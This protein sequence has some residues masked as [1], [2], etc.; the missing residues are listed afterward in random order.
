MRTEAVAPEISVVVPV[1][2]EEKNIRPFLARLIPTLEKIGPYEVIFSLDPCPDR[3][4]QVISEEIAKNP[5]I[6][7]LVFSRRFGQPAATMAGIYHSQGETVVAIDVDLQDPPELIAALYAKYKEGNDVVYAKRSSRKGET[8]IKKFV[9]YVGYKLINSISNFEIP[10]NTGDFRLMSRRVVENLK[11][12]KETN[13]FLR[14]LVGYVGFKQS[15]VVYERDERASG[16][17]NYNRY[18]GSLWIGINGIVGFSNELLTW[19]LF[20]GIGIA[21]LSFAAIIALAITFLLGRPYP[22]GIPTT[23]SLVL[24][25]GGVQLVCVGILG[26]YIGR[27]YDEVKQRPRFIVDRFVAHSEIVQQAQRQAIQQESTLNGHAN[28]FVLSG[29]SPRSALD[30]PVPTEAVQ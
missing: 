29:T 27:I 5:S 23:I 18:L 2:K 12:L 6:K 3:T 24:F 30:L 14:G 28:S 20:A 1:Y 4:E 8:V 13:C 19:V 22:M 17:G 25:M 11:L 10:R 26:Q 16:I 21:T 9:S 15:F 7:L